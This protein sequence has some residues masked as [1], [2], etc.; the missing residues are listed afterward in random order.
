MGTDP[1]VHES[2]EQS[3]KTLEVSANF[4]SSSKI[5]PGLSRRAARAE[6]EGTQGGLPE[7]LGRTTK[8][9]LDQKA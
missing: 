3:L 6:G 9:L 2:R 4:T 5:R 1:T 7:T 8:G